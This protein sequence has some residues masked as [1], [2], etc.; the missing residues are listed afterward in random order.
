[1]FQVMCY[2]IQYFAELHNKSL[3]TSFEACY[4]TM[5]DKKPHATGPLFPLVVVKMTA[6]THGKQLK[7][8]ALSANIAGKHIE[9]TARDL[10][11]QAVEH[12]LQCGKSAAWQKKK[13]RCFSHVSAYDTC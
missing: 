2:S 7:C 9:N 4:T 11:K 1:M 6:I 12:I 10:K 13:Y 3:E 8:T 5:K